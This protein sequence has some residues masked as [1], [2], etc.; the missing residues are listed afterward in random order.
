MPFA[1]GRQ[2]TSHLIISTAQRA[3]RRHWRQSLTVTT[4]F[5]VVSSSAARLG[6][7]VM[8]VCDEGSSLACRAGL[9]AF[10]DEY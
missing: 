10:R 3:A 8:G 4:R 2:Q 7:C 6:F 5:P 9:P 1:W